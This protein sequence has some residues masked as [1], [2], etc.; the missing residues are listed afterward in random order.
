M[1][2]KKL[3]AILRKMAKENDFDINNVYID[4]DYKYIHTVD[5]SKKDA[6]YCKTNYKGINYKVQYVSGCFNPFIVEDK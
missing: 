4:K 6:D 1:T 2:V 3:N 5:V